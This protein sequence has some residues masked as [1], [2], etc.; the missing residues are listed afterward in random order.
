M[1]MKIAS[2][3]EDILRGEKLDRKDIE[4][5]LTESKQNLW[6][7]LY[8]ANRIREKNFGNRV[9]LCSIVPGRQIGRAHV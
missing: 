4:V 2:I 6:D 8:W 1:N 7:L 9:R 3:A 5:L